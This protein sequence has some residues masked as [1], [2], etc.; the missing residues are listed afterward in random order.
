MQKKS[1]LFWIS[2]I[3][4]VAVVAGGLFWFFGTAGEWQKPEI[5]LSKD[6]R[7]LGQQG[8]LTLE[9]R[10][11]RGLSAASVRITQGSL[12]LPIAS[13]RFDDKPLRQRTVNVPIDPLALKLREGSAVLTVSASDRSLWN[14]TTVVTRP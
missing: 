2:L 10:D 12:T 14:N 7:S 11:N 13:V 1:S 4:A 9:L 3:S 5:R 8:V 6:L